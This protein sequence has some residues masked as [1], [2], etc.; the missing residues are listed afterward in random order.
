VHDGLGVLRSNP[1]PFLKIT[2]LF[3]LC[4][5]LAAFIEITVP[6]N[7]FWRPAAILALDFAAVIVAPVAT[8]M[9]VAFCCRGERVNTRLVLTSA[10]PWLPRYVWTNVHSSFIFWV[11][12]LSLL[13]MRSLQ[14]AWFPTSESLGP[15]VIVLWWSII[16][17]AGLFLHTRTL[18]APYMA[19]HSN[20]PGTM[21][22]LESWR[23][24][25]RH[26][27]VLLLTLLICLAPVV[28]PLAI[29]RVIVAMAIQGNVP[30][31]LVVG[32]AIPHLLWVWIQLVRLALIPP[33]YILYGD[34]W[35][36]E[37]D[38]RVED[39]KPATPRLARLLLA[40]TE[41]LPSI[42]LNDTVHSMTPSPTYG[43]E[44]RQRNN[45]LNEDR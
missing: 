40:A 37:L 27:K 12:I 21:A 45:P 25:A 35:E 29:V 15:Y 23:L 13:V 20:I 18:L 2:L 44:V 17:V 30:L 32:S 26:F 28:V 43:S 9:A 36:S 16:G 42:R 5:A 8:M 33:V 41:S 19:I 10:L 38:R 24:S 7:L 4:A 31:Q 3:S 6:H 1:G 11:P 22:V 34:L 14:E 39:G